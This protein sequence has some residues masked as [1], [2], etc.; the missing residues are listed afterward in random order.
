MSFKKNLGK[1]FVLFLIIIILILGGLLWFDRLGVVHIKSVFAPVYKLLGKEPQV[2][3]TATQTRPLVGDLDEDRINKQ[4][5]AINIQIE[6]LE[7]RESDL[8][9]AEQLNAQ[10][11]S[12]LEERQKNQ[13]E[14][15]KTFNLMKEQYD[16]RDKNIEQVARNLNGMKPQNAVE[17]LLNND[18]QFV[19]DVL[20]KCDEMAARDGT[21]SLTSYWLSLMPAER[22]AQINRKRV[23]K[24]DSLD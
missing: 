7:K 16:S 15:E 18:D 5:E 3:T 11:A 1:S 23:S 17:I 12:E 8:L 2:S 10:I 6:E 19:V 14:V 13:E 20:R 4:K 22:A 21:T 24:P 9:A